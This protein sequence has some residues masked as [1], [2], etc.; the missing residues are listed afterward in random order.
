M[1]A[2]RDGPHYDRM[3]D[4]YLYRVDRTWI[5]LLSEETEKSIDIIFANEYISDGEGI[6]LAL[7]YV[8]ITLGNLEHSSAL[9]CSDWSVH[10]PSGP[11]EDASPR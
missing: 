10:S 3:G 5:S 6:S 2:I 9:N 1:Q 11:D 7:F 8:R 4:N